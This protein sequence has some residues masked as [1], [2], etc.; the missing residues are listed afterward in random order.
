MSYERFPF[1]D[2]FLENGFCFRG[3]YD[4]VF[5]VLGF[6]HSVQLEIRFDGL[7]IISIM[8]SEFTLFWASF[9]V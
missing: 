2:S 7:N 4:G 5:N 1:N 3:D 9:C 8:N 6:G